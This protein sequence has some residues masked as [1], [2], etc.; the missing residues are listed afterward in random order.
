MTDRM[1]YKL[2][3]TVMQM[4]DDYSRTHQCKQKV[5]VNTL[6]VLT[7]CTIELVIAV[8]PLK[9]YFD[10]CCARKKINKQCKWLCQIVNQESLLGNSALNA[11]QRVCH[12]ITVAARLLLCVCSFL[13]KC[14]YHNTKVE[15]EDILTDRFYKK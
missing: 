11:I 8:T 9:N 1:D 12:S 13:D 15:K 4:M 10:N 14:F 6:S 5:F 7:D 2:C 3:F